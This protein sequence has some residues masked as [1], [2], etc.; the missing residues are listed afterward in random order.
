MSRHLIRTKRLEFTAPS[1]RFLS[2]IL[3]NMLVK[4]CFKHN[5][6]ALSTLSVIPGTLGLMESDLSVLYEL[7]T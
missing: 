1:T 6:S 2:V 7:L 5:L 4:V 3:N